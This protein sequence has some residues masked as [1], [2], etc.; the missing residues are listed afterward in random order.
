MPSTDFVDAIANLGPSALFVIALWAFLT[1]KVRREGEMKD[2]RAEGETRL[3]ELRV[4]RDQWKDIA[5]SS[6]ARLDRLTDV[7]ETLTGKSHT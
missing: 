3:A 1:G 4:D 7:V 6:L 5:N 2:S